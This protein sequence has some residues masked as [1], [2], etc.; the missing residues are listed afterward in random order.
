M[1]K[2]YFTWAL[3]FGHIFKEGS[4][5]D[6]DI[7]YFNIYEDDDFAIGW[8]V[9]TDDFQWTAWDYGG[10]I[11]HYPEGMEEL[12]WARKKY[13]KMTDDE[14]DKFCDI[15]GCLSNIDTY[16]KYESNK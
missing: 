10:N 1:N 9:G 11:V 3:L 13:S 15:F 5:L 7:S 8:W 14:F 2:V 4:K 6:E 12:E 16:I